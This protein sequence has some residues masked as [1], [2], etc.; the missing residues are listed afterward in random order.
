ME[1]WTQDFTF[2]RPSLKSCPGG[3]LPSFQPAGAE[4]FVLSGS[5]Q[6][7]SP[8]YALPNKHRAKDADNGMKHVRFL[9]EWLNIG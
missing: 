3:S 4:C 6:M 9:V 2:A 8:F 5:T 7:Y 1:M